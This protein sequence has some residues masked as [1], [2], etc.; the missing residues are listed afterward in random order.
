M[1]LFQKME[2]RM[3]KIKAQVWMGDYEDALCGSAEFSISHLRKEREM[4]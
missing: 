4:I 1:R 3:F 2:T